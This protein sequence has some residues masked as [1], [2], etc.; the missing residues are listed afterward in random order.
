MCYHR[1]GDSLDI[2]FDSDLDKAVSAKLTA[3]FRLCPSCTV[4]RG[5]FS[6]FSWISLEFPIASDRMICAME[7]WSSE[8]DSLRILPL[9]G[10]VHAFGR[11]SI[12]AGERLSFREMSL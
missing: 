5:H 9:F 4:L 7:V 6:G 1:E 2:Q 3:F 12:A 10:G 8:L 11:T